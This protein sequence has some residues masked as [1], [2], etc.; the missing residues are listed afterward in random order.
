MEAHMSKFALCIGINNYPGTE[1]DLSGCVNDA[2]DWAKELKGRGFDVKLLLDAVATKAA[3]ISEMRKV[4]A[5]AKSKDVVVI[6]FSGHGTWQPDDDDD[7]KDKRDE[8]LCPYDLKNGVLVDDDLFEVF[9]LRSTGVRLIMISDSC[10]SGTVAKYAPSIEGNKRGKIR[11]MPLALFEKDEQ[12]L[13]LAKRVQKA[14]A[15]GRSRAG[16]LLLSGCQDTEYSYDASFG[17]RPN[18]AFTRLAL[19]ALTNLA[20]SSTYLDWHRAI[21]SALPSMDYPQTP[22]IVATSAQKRWQIFE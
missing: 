10:H 20:P 9:D 19:N 14:P 7:E 17:N 2:N 6:T 18:G 12:K 11:Y 3:M 15:K 16:A 22:N 5:A 8:A 1:N 21:R 4:I 13:M